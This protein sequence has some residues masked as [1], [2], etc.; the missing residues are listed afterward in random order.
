MYIHVP[1]IVGDYARCNEF[2]SGVEAAD[3]T[4]DQ[5]HLPVLVSDLE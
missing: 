4:A 2:L 3:H 5:Q 1:D